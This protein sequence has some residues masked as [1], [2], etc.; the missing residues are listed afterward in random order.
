MCVCVEVTGGLCRGA[1]G[2]KCVRD[3]AGCVRGRGGSWL[4]FGLDLL[5]GRGVM[6]GARKWG[7]KGTGHRGRVC[8]GRGKMGRRADGA[9]RGWG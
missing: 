6:N 4:R 2:A 3:G 1:N 8:K 9:G 5:E 7:L